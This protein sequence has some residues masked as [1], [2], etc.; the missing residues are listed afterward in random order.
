MNSVSHIMTQKLK[1][2]DCLSSRL[3]RGEVRVRGGGGGGWRKKGSFREQQEEDGK[4]G[5]LRS[6]EINL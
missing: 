6:L 5:S 4:K 3:R 2:V 1:G